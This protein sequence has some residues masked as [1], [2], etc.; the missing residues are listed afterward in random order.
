VRI[1][2]IRERSIRISRYDDSAIPSGGLNTSAVAIVTDA[3]VRGERVVG[4]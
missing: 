1:V 4:Y 3:Y 2:D